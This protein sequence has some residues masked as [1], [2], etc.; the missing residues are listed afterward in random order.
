MFARSFD[1]RGKT[2]EALRYY[3]TVYA[4]YTGYLGISAPSVKRV[5]EI[6]WERNAAVGEQIGSGEKAVI[7]KKKDRQSAYEIGSTYIKSTAHI[8]ETNKKLS[9][10][11][12]AVWDKVAALAKKYEE[13]G[14]VKTLEEIKKEKK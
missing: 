10:E 4:G 14:D 11:D 2:E 13:S 12:K 1:E 7:L 9:D 3:G 5:L 6:M 8:R